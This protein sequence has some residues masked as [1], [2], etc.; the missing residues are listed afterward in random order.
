M[1]CAA[2]ARPRW[3]IR[4]PPISFIPYDIP[5]RPGVRARLV[6]PADLTAAEAERLCRT[7]RAVAFPD[8]VPGA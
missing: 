1:A 3:V 8:E 2:L 5:V 6:L 4:T 7:V